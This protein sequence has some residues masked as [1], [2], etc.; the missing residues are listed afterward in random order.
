MLSYSAVAASGGSNGRSRDERLRQ[1]AQQL[2]GEN[3]SGTATGLANNVP[4]VGLQLNATAGQTGSSSVQGLPQT[5]SAAP[6]AV[7]LMAA[8]QACQDNI[9]DGEECTE[10]EILDEM[11][12]EVLRRRLNTQMGKRGKREKRLS[13]QEE[14]VLEQQQLIA[15]E[16]EKLLELQAAVEATNEEIASIS[17]LV[18]IFSRRIAELSADTHN[19]GDVPASLLPT[20][21][22]LEQLR[23]ASEGTMAFVRAY[24]GWPRRGRRGCFKT[25]G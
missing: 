3:K 7:Q 12:C 17:S 9:D 2:A 24:F 1:S 18:H 14:A 15:R 5:N 21:S 20:N 22:F 8:D 11:S 16:N 19:S 25:I 13:K 6:S 10:A 4:P 23:A